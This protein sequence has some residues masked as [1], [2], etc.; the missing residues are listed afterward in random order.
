MHHTDLST[1]IMKMYPKGGS[2]TVFKS[3]DKTTE[4]FKRILCCAVFFAC[5][6]RHVVI[7]PKLNAPEKNYAYKLIY[8]NLQGTKFYGK[9]PDFSVDGIFYEHEGYVNKNPK[10]NLSNMLHRGLKQSNRIIIEDCGLTDGYIKRT[11]LARIAAN[12]DIK[13]IYV[14]TGENLRLVF[15]AE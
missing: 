13:E 5:Q 11:I 12:Q 1:E 10:T 6:G 3:I 4:D 2:I 14:K 15:K 9:C 7:T 8:G